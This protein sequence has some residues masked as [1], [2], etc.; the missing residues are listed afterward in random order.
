M[1]IWHILAAVAEA[2]GARRLRLAARL[3]ALLL[4]AALLDAGQ[5]LLGGH[6]AAVLLPR[7]SVW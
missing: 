5:H 2:R 6:L 1:R 4:G 3:A 7:L